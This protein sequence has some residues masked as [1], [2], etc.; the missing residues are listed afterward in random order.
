LRF[1]SG[2][3]GRNES[4]GLPDI[5]LDTDVFV[6]HLRGVRRLEGVADQFVYSVVTRAELFAG[7]HTE[8]ATVRR[9]L[10]PMRE[11]V[12]DRAIAERAG[13]IRRTVPILLPDALIAATALELGV[14]L[15]TRNR[16]DYEV[17]TGLAVVSPPGS[18]AA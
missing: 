12:V 11:V 1:P 4:R 9:L 8:E 10:A 17:V 18:G 3:S 14:P 2:A 13:S 16:R 6:D 15:M 7:R 5:L